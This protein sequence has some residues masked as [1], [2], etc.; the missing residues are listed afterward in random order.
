MSRLSLLAPLLVAVLIV[1]GCT[2]VDNL[3]GS[4]PKLDQG[5]LDSLERLVP[6]Q[7]NRF[8]FKLFQELYNNDENIMIS[9]VSIAMALHMA[10]NGAASETGKAM[11]DVLQISGI[12]L[13]TLN[14]SNLALLYNLKTADPKV[15]LEIANSLWARESFTLEPGF[16]KRIED[17]YQAQ[18]AG[19]DFNNPEAAGI[20]NKWVS[21]NTQGLIKEIVQAPIDPLTVMFLINAV[22]FKG[23]WTRQFNKNATRD[24]DFYPAFGSPIKV[25]MMNQNGSYEYLET[26]QFQA[27]RLPYGEEGRL[28]MYIFLPAENSDLDRFLQDLTWETWQNHLADFK[29]MPGTISLPRFTLEFEN[30]L[31]NALK[32]LGMDI[33]FAPGLADF[34]LMT[35]ANVLGDLFISDV[36]HKTFISVDEEGTEAAAVTS[37]EVMVTS[38]PMEDF[39]MVVNRP[40]FYAIH[41]RETGAI[42]F[43]GTVQN[44]V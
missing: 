10:Y 9:P 25:P 12:D 28:A 7:N 20:I 23:T 38:A 41:D 32:A 33:A 5:I 29:R 15:R 42:L 4:M 18:V 17:Y 8:G 35:P 14:A 1:T 22:Y 11:A 36:K 40:F 39:R 43:M 6:E 19:L 3:A 27:V 44:P 2:P 26:R 16:L 13:E 30:S 21:D 31:A 37:V 24:G 34:S